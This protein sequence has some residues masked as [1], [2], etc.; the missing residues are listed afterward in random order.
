MKIYSLSLIC[1]VL[2]SL[3]SGSYAAVPDAPNLS[4]ITQD[5]LV[6]MSWTPLADASG[7]TL[8]YAPK[9]YTG[10]DSVLTADLG[11]STEISAKLSRGLSF[12]VAIEA[13][14]QD[15]KGPY[16]NV[17]D[18]KITGDADNCGS[19][20]DAFLDYTA[21][22]ST[23]CDE[24]YFYIHS[25][26][27]LPAPS[28]VEEDKLMVGIT[29]WIKRV[30]LPAEHTWKVSLEPKW[31]AG[32]YE[33]VSSLGPIAI[34]SNGVP[35]LYM[36]KRPDVGADPS[37]YDP[38]FDT[39]L[40]GELDQ[41]GG[42]AGQGE[43][44]HYHYA[45][46]C[47]LDSHDLSRPIAFGLDGAPIF[48]GTGGTDYYGRGRYNNIN[49]LPNDELDECNALLQEDGSYIH[50]TTAEA[51]YFIGCYR[52]SLDTS[53][54]NQNISQVRDFGQNWLL[55]RRPDGMTI[56]NFYTDASNWQH[57]VLTADEDSNR[58][59]SSEVIYRETEDPTDGNCW[60]F[61]FRTEEGVS[62]SITEVFCHVFKN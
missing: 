44:Y 29:G 62:S 46:I 8:H 31:L 32:S 20:S 61:E 52:A 57:L 13:Y 11:L 49:N 41:C 16:S 22:V 15:G 48:Y 6:K 12:Y 56:T 54:I 42:H 39:V 34:A 40:L 35:M 2:Y 21:L 18:F 47:M 7:Y 58:V 51:P 1:I 28:T 33:E 50:Y 36:D 43:D 25:V 30:P 17:R 23:S 38:D 4:I 5:Q 55:D 45:P 10:A 24:N 19:K 59:G 37:S 60:D 3:N 53:L 14:N 26:N 27:S 9:P